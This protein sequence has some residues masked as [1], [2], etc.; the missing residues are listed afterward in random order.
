[1]KLKVGTCQFPVK[2]DVRSNL[3]YV[4]EQMK[5]AKDRGSQV[6]HFSECALSGYGG[7]EFTTFEGY[8]WSLLEQCTQQV[9]DLARKLRL[10]VVL[11]SSHRLGRRLKAHNCHYIINDRGRIIDRYDKMFCAGNRSEKTG[12]FV[13]YRPGNH[14]CIFSIKGIKCGVQICH[15]FRYQE[16]YREHYKRGVQL[17]FHAFHMGGRTKASVTTKDDRKWAS[18]VPATMQTYAANNGM[19]ISV[20]NTSRRYSAL[21]SFFVELGGI[22]TG[23]LHNQQAGVLISTIDTNKTSPDPARPWRD[24][25]VRGIFHSGTLIK[26]KRTD[27]RTNY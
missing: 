18:I 12:D 9:M 6:V 1:M 24:R 8:D 20:N 2:A 14:F 22:I 26:D 13:N 16:V 19:R 23:R 4:L 15:D 17:M 11:G 5:K 25:A 27:C 7:C 3:R 10:W 21:P